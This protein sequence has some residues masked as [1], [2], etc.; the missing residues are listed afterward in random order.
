MTVSYLAFR[1]VRRITGSLFGGARLNS[2][3]T[4]TCES[5]GG[6][7]GLNNRCT[8]RATSPSVFTYLPRFASLCMSN[9]WGGSSTIELAENG[10]R[11]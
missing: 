5:A 4:V 6:H 2:T 11:D 10:L 1:S 9:P 7:P 3:S 8:F